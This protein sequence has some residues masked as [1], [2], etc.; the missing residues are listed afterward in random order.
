[1]KY[2]TIKGLD[3]KISRIVVGTRDFKDIGQCFEHYDAFLE[4]GYTAWDTAH[5]YN[6]GETDNLIGEWMR[7][8]NVR[9][10]VV[11]IAKGCHPI[12]ERERVSPYNIT[13]ELLESLKRLRTDYVDIYMLHRDDPNVEIGLIVETLHK[14]WEEGRIKVYGGSNWSH[15]R[16]IEANEY[17]SKHG[18]QPFTVSDPQFSLLGKI[19]AESDRFWWWDCVSIGGSAKKEVREWY[20]KEGIP[21]FGYSALA[22]GFLSGNVTPDNIESLIKDGK[23]PGLS[24]SSWYCDENMGYLARTI[25]MSKRKGLTVPQVAL[26][27]ITSLA[28]NG[29]LDAY[30]IAASRKIEH[31]LEN[32]VAVEEDFSAEEIAWL[33]MRGDDIT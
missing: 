4:A 23:L 1:M 13:S 10:K 7:S 21:I 15:K 28:A 12:G 16:I 17:A 9:D 14:H 11:V 18:L 22:D 6:D 20:R 3:K 19:D 25:E 24:V 32:T 5:I 2:G 27:Y 31:M 26:R 8:R 29:I 30:A 33:E